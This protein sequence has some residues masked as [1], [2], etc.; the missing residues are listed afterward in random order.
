MKKTYLV[1]SAL[2]AAMLI[3]SCGEG[4]HQH[5]DANHDG[6]CDGC[7][8]VGMVFEHKDENHDHKCDECGQTF[9]EHKDSNHEDKCDICGQDL[10]KDVLS[11][12]KYTI[13]CFKLNIPGIV[14]V[15]RPGYYHD[16][17]IPY[18]KQKS[19]V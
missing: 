8:A 14:S 16:K 4:A 13:K 15:P 19:S 17:I 10:K 6:V 11:F 9:T 3:T 2:A 18:L 1:L 12:F 5:V 7:G